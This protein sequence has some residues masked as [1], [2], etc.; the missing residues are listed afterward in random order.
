M[1]SGNPVGVHGLALHLPGDRVDLASWCRWTGSDPGKV[2][3][4]VGTSFRM[5][6]SHRDV[7]GM[8]R[9]SALSLAERGL[10]RPD[11][12]GLLVLATESSL[13]NAA[14]PSLILESLEK[15][16]RDLGLPPLSDRCEALEIK[17][18]CLAGV[19]GLAA[20]VRFLALEEPGRQALV[21]ASD[22]ALYAEGSTGEPTQ[23]AGAVAMVLQA[24]PGLLE[25]DPGSLA[26][27]VRWRPGDFR[28]PLLPPGHPFGVPSF[29]GPWSAACYLDETLRVVSAL[30]DR[31]G[32]SLAGL[33]ED[34]A[35]VLAHRPY[36][37]MPRDALA[38]WCLQA[39]PDVRGAVAERLGMAPEEVRATLLRGPPAAGDPWDEARRILRAARD[40]SGLQERLARWMDPGEIAMSQCGNLYA[41][42]LP[43][44]IGAALEDCA[45]RGESLAGRPILLVGYGS[46]N[47]AMALSARVASGWR[48]TLSR[49]VVS[50]A[51]AGATDLDRDG[52]RER[53]RRLC[54][55]E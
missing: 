53:H 43:A 4:T 21:V 2:L 28:K 40:H 42:A 27:T 34:S 12:V 46:G 24:D 47:G 36:R 37:K 30:V 17:Q 23:G 38:L 7:Y 44:W 35:L 22:I 18:A 13:D 10:L 8:A 31:L 33:L 29:D 45:A 41:A 26:A 15:G 51:L 9:E 14:G 55:G 11:R 52:Y 19:L 16:L 50:A 20:A 25:I 1:G 49:C 5:P 6:R 32:S 3:G 48:E 39:F 54:E